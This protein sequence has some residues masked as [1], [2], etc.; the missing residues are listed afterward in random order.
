M[1]IFENL[2]QQKLGYIPDSLYDSFLKKYLDKIKNGKKTNEK[3]KIY[4]K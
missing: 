1:N 3:M 2:L 4:S